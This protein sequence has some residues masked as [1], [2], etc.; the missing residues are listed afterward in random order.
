MNKWDEQNSRDRH[1]YGGYQRERP[2]KVEEGKGDQIYG[3]GR[4]L[5]CG[6]LIMQYTDDAL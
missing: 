3:D 5:L 1:Q 4:R 6:E 2:G